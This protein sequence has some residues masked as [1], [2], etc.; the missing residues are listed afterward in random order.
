MGRFDYYEAGSWDV[1]CDECGFKYK[2]EGLR[3]RWD[4][5]MVCERCWEPRQ[6]QD[7]VRGIVDQQAPPWTRP[8][9]YNDN[10]FCTTF[11]G[12]P[13]PGVA[14]VGCAVVGRSYVA[15]GYSPADLAAFE[16]TTM[17]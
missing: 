14:V 17:V 11:G 13:T 16:G 10:Y 5:F 7:F 2:A 6:P 3:L 15:F 4:G 8:D 1:R 12:F 9:T